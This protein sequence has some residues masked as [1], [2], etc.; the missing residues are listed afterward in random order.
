LTKT[1]KAHPLILSHSPQRTPILALSLSLSLSL[2]LKFQVWLKITTVNDHHWQPPSFSLSSLYLFAI[3]DHH[4]L[5][6]A[7]NSF[8]DIYTFTCQS[9]ASLI[10]LQRLEKFSFIS[11]R[12]LETSNNL[13]TFGLA[14]SQSHCNAPTHSRIFSHTPHGT[15]SK[16]GHPTRPVW[17]RHEHDPFMLTGRGSRH[18]TLI[19]RVT[20]HDP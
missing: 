8:S 2:S 3:G 13:P 12:P 20:R 7:S 16:T 4:H 5:F 19:L 9:M 1:S 18:D 6:L 14:I 11:S 15:T 10:S 17:P